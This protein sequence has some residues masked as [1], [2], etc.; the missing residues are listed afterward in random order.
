V[1]EEENPFWKARLLF[2]E[3][4]RERGIWQ[5]SPREKRRY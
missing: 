4:R 1:D 2:V 5:E 3:V